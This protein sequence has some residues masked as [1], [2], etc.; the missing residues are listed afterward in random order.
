MEWLE[1]RK[2]RRQ[3][4]KERKREIARL[5]RTSEERHSRLVTL[6]PRELAE[7][8]VSSDLGGRVSTGDTAKLAEQIGQLTDRERYILGLAA[9]GLSATQIAVEL[10]EPVQRVSMDLKR[11]LKGHASSS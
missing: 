2:R 6:T 9:E 4:R 8:V 5:R 7:K 1:Q 3:E 11:I 10:F